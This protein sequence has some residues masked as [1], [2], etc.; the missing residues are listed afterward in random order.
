MYLC[1]LQQEVVTMPTSLVDDS[2]PPNDMFSHGPLHTIGYIKSWK[3]VPKM[4]AVIS[5]KFLKM[6]DIK[7][8]LFKNLP[9]NHS[10]SRVAG[11]EVNV[12]EMVAKCLTQTDNSGNVNPDHVIQS[13]QQLFG[14]SR[15]CISLY[16]MYYHIILDTS[17]FILELWKFLAISSL[18]EQHNIP[19]VSIEL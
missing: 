14:P 5:P 16:M 12:V 13:T 4:F 1:S 17:S 10:Q 15:K 3:L 8:W 11:G 7:A 6:A 9:S 19:N 2:L 18:Q